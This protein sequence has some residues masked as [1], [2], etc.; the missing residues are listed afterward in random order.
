MLQA[1]ADRSMLEL[2]IDQLRRRH[3]VRGGSC[4]SRMHICTCFCVPARAAGG[5]VT[6]RVVQA[7]V[8]QEALQY[9]RVARE[10]KVRGL[11]CLSVG[12]ES[13]ALRPRRCADE[14]A[15]DVS[16]GVTPLT[17]RGRH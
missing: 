15:A 17:A 9:R 2:E 13:L 6:W 16:G 5:G 10:Q 1:N 12:Q 3:Q 8:T 11:V 4:L 7:D 14:G